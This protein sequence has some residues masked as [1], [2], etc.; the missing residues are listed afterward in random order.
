MNE[1]ELREFRARFNIPISDDVIA[2]MPFYPSAA[3]QRRR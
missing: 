2:D 3:G 1:K